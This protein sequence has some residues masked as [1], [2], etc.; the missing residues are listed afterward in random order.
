MFLFLELVL[1]IH[2][3]KLVKSVPKN[4]KLKT[5]NI[6]HYKNNNLHNM[7]TKQYFKHYFSNP[8]QILSNFDIKNDQL[9]PLMKTVSPI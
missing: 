9:G 5:F 3:L 8:A 1:V 6:K 4:L 7:S 2:P